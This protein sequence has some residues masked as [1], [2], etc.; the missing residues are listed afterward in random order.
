MEHFYQA[1]LQGQPPAAALRDTLVA[2]RAMT[3]FELAI[4]FRRW[5]DM[6]AAYAAPL[7]NLANTAMQ[8]GDAQP[9]ADPRYWA[10]FML[11]GRPT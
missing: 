1:Q 2:V 9:Y 3:G 8:Q 10:P 11:I 4:T 7:E 6:Y 5:R